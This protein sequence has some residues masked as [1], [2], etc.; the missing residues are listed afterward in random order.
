MLLTFLCRMCYKIQYSKPM[1]ESKYLLSNLQAESRELPVVE[2][3]R[4]Q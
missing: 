1:K 2:A 4:Q 3:Q